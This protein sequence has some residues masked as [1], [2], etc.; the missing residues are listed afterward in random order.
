MLHPQ[1]FKLK[2]EQK[3]QRSKDMFLERGVPTN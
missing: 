2:F 1:L 3:M